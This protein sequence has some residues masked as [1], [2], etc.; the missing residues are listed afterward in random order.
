MTPALGEQRVYSGR[1]GD[2]AVALTVKRVNYTTVAYK[3]E[4]VEFGKSSHN[5]SGQADMVSSF[6]LGTESDEDVQTGEG[7]FVTEYI[8]SRDKDCYTHIRLGDDNER[9]KIIKTC[10]G[11]IRDITLDNFKTLRRK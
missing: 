5:Q 7:Y 1:E 4:M 9:A 8:E 11:K 6:F 2:L 10:N 3:I